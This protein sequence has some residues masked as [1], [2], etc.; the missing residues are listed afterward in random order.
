MGVDSRKGVRQDEERNLIHSNFPYSVIH[1][2]CVA[3]VFPVV[4]AEAVN[5]NSADGRRL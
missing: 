1:R 2:S 3:V 5:T 4:D